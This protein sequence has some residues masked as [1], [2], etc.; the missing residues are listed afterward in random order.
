[1]KAV[2]SDRIY[3]TVTPN[4]QKKIDG[5]LT[6]AIPSFR[7]DD[8]PIMIKNMALIRD[9]LIAIPSGRMDLIPIDHEIVDKRSIKPI[10]NKTFMTFIEIVI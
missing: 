1:M 6:Y 4:Q 7:F 2:I 9:G 3:L 8:P 5:E 10:K